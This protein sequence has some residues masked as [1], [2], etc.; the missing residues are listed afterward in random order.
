M[1][2]L[3]CED[4]WAPEN[5]CFWTVVLEKTLES[6]LDSKEIQYINPKRN[7]SWIFIGRADVEVETPVLWPLDAK[8]WLIWK[9]P[10]LK[11]K[12]D[13][14]WRRGQQ[15]M[16][17]LDGI[18]DSVVMSLSKLRELVMD[19]EAWH[20]AVY[21]VATSWTRLWDWTEPNWTDAFSFECI[22]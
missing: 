3:D 11:R 5:W 1:W 13:G 18:T 14:E 4:S 12:I 6:L 2:E 15:R 10:H 20:A 9:D 7:Q 19:R 8:S 21:G 17:W 16:I 22:N